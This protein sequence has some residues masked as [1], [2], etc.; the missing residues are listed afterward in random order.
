MMFVFSRPTHPTSDADFEELMNRN[1]AVASTAITKAVSSATAGE[2]CTSKS[3]KWNQ[4]Y[5]TSQVIRLKEWSF[6]TTDQHYNKAIPYPC[7]H[8]SMELKDEL[9]QSCA[10]VFWYV[11]HDIK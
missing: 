5:R 7:N 4:D 6:H 2:Y 10:L 9:I 3:E 1:R 11:M 8:I